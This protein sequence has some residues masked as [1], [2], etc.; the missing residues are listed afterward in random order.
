[1]TDRPTHSHHNM[2]LT[3]LIVESAL[4]LA[5][6][7]LAWLL[8]RLPLAGTDF[9]AMTWPQVSWHLVA[10]VA[11]TLPLVFLLP[12]VERVPWGP[13]VRLNQ[14]VNESL[15]PLF[16]GTKVWQM[17]FIALAAGIG[18][19]IFFRSFLQ[20]AM[21]DLTGIWWLG[22]LIASVV[23]GVCHWVTPTYAVVA[24]AIGLYLGLLFILTNSLIAPVVAHALYD[25]IAL[26]YLLRLKSVAAGGKDETSTELP[27]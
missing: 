25:F 26:F 7:L 5:A 13:L 2:A 10:G 6:L 18:E 19:E 24:T 3:A 1:M 12:L 20:S 8:G 21:T 16:A 11:A 9:S 27:S 4:A 15:L 22:L 17:A 23:F 14:V